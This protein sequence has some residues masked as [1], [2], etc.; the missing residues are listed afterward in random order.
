[1]RIGPRNL[2]GRRDTLRTGDTGLLLLLLST[3]QQPLPG[4]LQRWADDSSASGPDAMARLRCMLTERR[5]STDR[6]DDRPRV[7]RE[8]G[9]SCPGSLPGVLISQGLEH[10]VEPGEAGVLAATNRGARRTVLTR[11][12]V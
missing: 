9:L 5:W 2:L 10:W 6:T 4:A 11:E 7:T 12:L 8:R 3:D 1:M